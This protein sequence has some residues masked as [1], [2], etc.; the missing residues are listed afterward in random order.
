MAVATSIFPDCG[1][2]THFSR[3]LRRRNGILYRRPKVSPPCLR[4]DPSEWHTFCRPTGRHLRSCSSSAAAASPSLSLSLTSSKSSASMNSS[5]RLSFSAACSTASKSDSLSS[6]SSTTAAGATLGGATR[7][8]TCLFVCAR[9]TPTGWVGFVWAWVGAGFVPF[10]LILL[11]LGQ[12]TAGLDC[13][14][15]AWYRPIQHSS[16]SSV[17]WSSI[18]RFQVCITLRNAHEVSTGAASAVVVPIRSS[19]IPTW[20]GKRCGTSGR[21]S[22]E[23]HVSWGTFISGRITSAGGSGTPLTTL[24]SRVHPHQGEPAA[25][26][27]RTRPN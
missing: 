11:W 6:L 15:M 23:H 24:A 10:A 2:Q 14:G 9:I 7:S 13:V 21:G 5:P 1:G 27:S 4:R 12:S 22:L 16:D 19:T 17:V 25:D 20:E 18:V 3:R 8:R 26:T